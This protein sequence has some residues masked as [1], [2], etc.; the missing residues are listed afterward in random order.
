MPKLINSISTESRRGSQSYSISLTSFTNRSRGKNR[1]WAKDSINPTPTHL[2]HTPIS[3]HH[4]RHS[5]TSHII[6]HYHRHIIN[7]SNHLHHNSAPQTPRAHSPVAYNLHHD[8]QI[9]EPHIR[10]NI[11]KILTLVNFP[12]AM[13]L[14]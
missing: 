11:M 8:P 7:S 4:L 5:T 13:M 9:T 1:R 12:C 14:P 6:S 10:L 3:L 2:H